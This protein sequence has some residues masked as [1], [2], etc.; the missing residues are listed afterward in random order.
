MEITNVATVVYDLSR[1]PASREFLSHLQRPYFKT[2]AYLDQEKDIAKWLDSGRASI[3]VVIPSDFQRKVEGKGQAEIQV[4]TDGALAMPATIAVAYI[5][6]ISSKYSTSV[7]KERAGAVGMNLN[8]LPRLDEQVRVKFNPNM[9]SSW[10][11]SLLELMNM[12]TMVSLLL[13]AA[14]LVKEKEH[15]TLEQLLVSPVRTFEVFLAKIIPTLALVL[16]LS[17]LSIFLV[18]KPV[19]GVPIRGSLF[20]FYSAAV[21][22]VFAMTSLGIA[23]AVVA[24][25]LSQAMMIMLLILQ[26][27]LFLSGAWNPPEAM[28]PWMRKMSIISPM[29]YFIDFGF[30]VLL[31]G[32]GL[33]LVAWDIVGMLVFGIALFSFSLCWFQRSLSR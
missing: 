28:N 22:Y 31:K 21:L 16:G 23:I 10:F 19:F 13:T 18:A 14:D 12:I 32:N 5:A 15:G 27:M 26:P 8:Q 24:R 4:I 1:G 29:R 6:Q 9:E 20:L 7:L 11:S 30:G 33:A 25:N 17:V 3:V 2:V